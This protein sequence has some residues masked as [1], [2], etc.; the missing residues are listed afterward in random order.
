MSS[1]QIAS[2]RNPPVPPQPTSTMV[3]RRSSRSG[4]ARSLPASI[5]Y[6]IDPTFLSGRLRMDVT[7]RPDV[8]LEDRLPRHGQEMT[9]G[10]HPQGYLGSLGSQLANHTVQAKS[11]F[12]AIV[13]RAEYCWV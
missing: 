12:V 13:G 6:G 1:R 11:L 7:E 2:A 4:A 10:A 5:T 8:A 9:V 3:A